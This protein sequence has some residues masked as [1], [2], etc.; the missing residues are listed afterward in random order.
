MGSAYEAK[1]GLYEHF[2]QLL[3]VGTEDWPN[4]AID[5][6]KLPLDACLSEHQMGC[7]ADACYT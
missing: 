1:V 6:L 2:N 3:I 4:D 7:D 5:D